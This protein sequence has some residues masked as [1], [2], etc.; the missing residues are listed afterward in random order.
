MTQT[1]SSK[2]VGVA[3]GG[4][5]ARAI[6]AIGVLEVL[7]EHNI[8]IDMVSGCSAG[9][10]VATTYATG[11]MSDLKRRLLTIQS[12]ESRRIIASLTLSSQ[13]VFTGEGNRRFF[14]EFL[15]EKNFSDTRLPLVLVAT[16]LRKMQEVVMSDGNLVRAVCACMMVPGI[17]VPVED[18]GQVLVDGGHFNLLPTRPLYDRGME[19]VIAVNVAQRPNAFTRTLS[20]VKQLLNIQPLYTRGRAY[21]DGRKPFHLFEIMRRSIH[22]SS[23]HIQNFHHSAYPYDMLIQPDVVRIKRWHISRTEH[24]VNQGRLAALAAIPQIKKDLGLL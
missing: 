19:Y 17:Y 24:L 6:A 13:G 20:W 22:L 15:G 21:T 5:F 16:D 23:S 9:A 4:G 8:P 10:G 2:K 3:L 14:G 18:N 7:N 12:S 1:T 11:T